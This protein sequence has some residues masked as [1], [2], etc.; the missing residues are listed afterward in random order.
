M[1]NVSHEIICVISLPSILHSIFIQLL[2]DLMLFI[3]ILNRHTSNISISCD[4]QPSVQFRGFWRNSDFLRNIIK[5]STS[6]AKIGLIAVIITREL[7]KCQYRTLAGRLRWSTACLMITSS[8]SSHGS[9]LI[10]GFL[11]VSTTCCHNSQISSTDILM[12]VCRQIYAYLIVHFFYALYFLD[13][14]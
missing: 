7:S 4:V 5:L 9:H 1:A 11:E 12:K 2:I 14:I 8:Q 10:L 3:P 6:H 13:Y